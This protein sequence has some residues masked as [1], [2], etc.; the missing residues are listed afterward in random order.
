MTPPPSGQDS[1]AWTTVSPL[2]SG[3]SPHTTVSSKPKASTRKRISPRA[4]RARSVG[5]TVGGGASGVVM[6]PTLLH[7]DGEDDDVVLAGLVHD[8]EHP[9]DQRVQR[10]AGPAGQR[11]HDPGGAGV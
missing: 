11:L 10:Q 1:C 4:S 3:W 9:V 7:P 8:L 6:G 2:P 5:Q